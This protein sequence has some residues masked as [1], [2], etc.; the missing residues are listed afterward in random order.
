LS[1]L[2]GTLFSVAMLAAFLLVGFGIKFALGTE[3]RKN[4]GLMI[5]AGLVIVANVLIWA[6]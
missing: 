3:H 6:L 5:V 1:G 4:G 2:I